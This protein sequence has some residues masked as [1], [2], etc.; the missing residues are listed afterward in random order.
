MKKTNIFSKKRR[1]I[2]K[3]ITCY[4]DADYHW[5]DRFRC[6][7]NTKWDSQTDFENLDDVRTSLHA[8]GFTADVKKYYLFIYFD[9][10][11]SSYMI[12]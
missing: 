2:G 9:V 4:I 8:I 6:L 11:S 12:G 3:K 5:L 1:N 10:L 7:S